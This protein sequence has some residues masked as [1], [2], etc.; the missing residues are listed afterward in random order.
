MSRVSR[1][2]RIAVAGLLAVS[3]L[4]VFGVNPA[5][6]AATGS[7]VNNGAGGVTVTYTIGQGESVGLHVYT[8]LTACDTSSLPPAPQYYLLAGVGNAPFLG[9]SPATVDQTTSVHAGQSSST[10]PTGTYMFCL[11]DNSGGGFVLLS[12]VQTTIGTVTPT[13]SSTTTSTTTAPAADPVAP[14]FT[15]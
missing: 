3:A 2:V 8:A 6:A 11:Y 15:G 5:G 13:T 7:V 1:S 9:A 4:T 14:A 10:I 12:G